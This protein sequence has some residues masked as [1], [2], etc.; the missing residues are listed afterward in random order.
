MA[1][2]K[3]GE[4]RAAAVRVGKLVRDFRQPIPD[5]DDVPVVE[6]IMLVG[7][8]AGITVVGG[9]GD[10][11]AVRVAGDCDS[12]V[13]Y[14]ALG[15]LRAAL[16]GAKAAA[17]VELTSTTDGL[18]VTVGNRQVTLDAY[19]FAGDI[20]TR[21]N[22]TAA[23]IGG[24][25]GRAVE[26][27]DM[28]AASSVASTDGTRPILQ[29]VYVWADGVA[30]TDSYRLVR[31]GTIGDPDDA[32]AVPSWAIH[33]SDTGVAHVACADGDY[34]FRTSTSAATY[35]AEGAPPDVRKLSPVNGDDEGAWA[36]TP[37][38]DAA[39]E[40]KSL[41]NDLTPC[42]L[43]PRAGVV[44]CA[45][46]TGA[47]FPVGTTDAPDSSPAVRYNPRYLAEHL[48]YG[49]AVVHQ[50]KP[51]G[52]GPDDRRSLLM[53]VRV[54][55]APM[56][57]TDNLPTVPDDAPPAPKRTSKPRKPRAD[58]SELDKL[59]AELETVR[60]ELDADRDK[61]KACRSELAAVRA[62]RTSAGTTDLADTRAIAAAAIV[63]ALVALGATW[64]TG[65]PASEP[66][67]TSEPTAPTAPS[68]PSEPTSRHGGATRAAAK[69]Y[70]QALHRAGIVATVRRD[71]DNGTLMLELA[72]M[73]QRADAER[74]A[75][76]MGAP[77]AA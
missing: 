67:A 5:N 61:L 68:E 60:A 71:R 34:T 25:D 30:A 43:A 49:A 46:E 13:A 59:R 52:A 69:A 63:P 37:R 24:A 73:A 36:F 42:E 75:A 72:D 7:S 66:T 4:L 54:E 40:L 50:L 10:A 74:I 64:R 9:I 44:W 76:D 31:I 41:P 58:R 77:I 39:R 18:V 51:T 35:R 12:L 21:W 28:L 29:R 3:A 45:H 47:L 70:R 33:K 27:A 22:R 1:G 55:S 56:V 23:A 11:L 19:G 15:S 57:P 53:P 26:L 62:D 2:I 38:A 6:P 65:R 48:A 32:Y 17:A 14:V 8:S 20:V 16:K